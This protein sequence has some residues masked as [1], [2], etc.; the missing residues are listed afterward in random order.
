MKDIRKTIPDSNHGGTRPVKVDTLVYHHIVGDAPA[1]IARFRQPNVQ[2]SSTYII[3]S[4]GEVYYTVSENLIPYTN[5]SYPSNCRSITIE[6]A[7]GTPSVPYTEKMYQASIKLCADLR[8]R[9]DIKNFKRHSDIIATECPGKLDVERIVKESTPSMA[10]GNYKG[11]SA[12]Y[13]H[14]RYQDT[15]KEKSAL[16][17][18]ISK[19]KGLIR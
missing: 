8:K 5:G 2:V 11:H 19:I 12:Q 14:R 4:D 16:K 10:T 18:V 6:H 1:A 3:G 17:L 13:W 9:Y 7:G 15:L